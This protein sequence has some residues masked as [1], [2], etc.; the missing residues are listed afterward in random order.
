MWAS[1]STLWATKGSV[2]AILIVT[3]FRSTVPAA[4]AATMFC[5]LST[6]T[7]NLVEI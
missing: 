1:W 6:D 4:A 2:W 7:A 3:V 5:G